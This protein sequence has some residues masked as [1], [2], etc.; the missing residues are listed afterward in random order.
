MEMDVGSSYPAHIGFCGPVKYFT[1][2]VNLNDVTGIYLRYLLAG[3]TRKN[4]SVNLRFGPSLKPYMLRVV[5]VNGREHSD[6]QLEDF[7]ENDFVEICN[8]LS[9]DF[10]TISREKFARTLL[11]SIA[12]KYIVPVPAY[13]L[14]IY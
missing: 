7:D 13:K 11:L 14:D 6:W 9:L 10:K 5:T 4:S 2:Y 12:P 3:V 1:E 8:E